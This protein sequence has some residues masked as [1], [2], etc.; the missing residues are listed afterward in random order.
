MGQPRIFYKMAQDGLMFKIY[1]K[2]N[3]RTGVPTALVACFVNL[4]ALANVTSLG[5]LQVFTFSARAAANCRSR[6]RASSTSV[7]SRRGNKL[8]TTI[9]LPG[10]CCCMYSTTPMMPM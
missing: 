1:A 7:A 9:M 8:F 4:E 3:R 6:S 5:T 2:V 10:R